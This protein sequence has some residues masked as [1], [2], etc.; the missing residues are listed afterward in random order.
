[1]TLIDRF[2][3]SVFD[4]LAAFAGRVLPDPDSQRTLGD[5]LELDRPKQKIDHIIQLM[6]STLGTRYRRQLY[7][8]KRE[9]D[10]LPLDR[11][12]ALFLRLYAMVR[13]VTLSWMTGYVALVST[14]C[15][16][17]PDRYFIDG[18][19]PLI[20]AVMLVA[21]KYANEQSWTKRPETEALLSISYRRHIDRIKSWLSVMPVGKLDPKKAPVR[22][23]LE[24]MTFFWAGLIPVYVAY[25]WLA[26]GDV[27]AREATPFSVYLRFISAVVMLVFWI[28][29]KRANRTVAEMLEHEIK[30]FKP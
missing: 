20:A 8:T 5:I 15:F 19:S 17:L 10:A 25:R 28:H 27:V 30:T 12:H 3:S 26:F 21:L 13:R 24:L 18:I 29:V 14:N 6:R 22:T 16:I 11:R 2:E 4:L 9:R 1:M 7:L 23:F